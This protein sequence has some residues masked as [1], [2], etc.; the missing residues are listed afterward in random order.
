MDKSEETRIVGFERG[1]IYAKKPDTLPRRYLYKVKSASRDGLISRWMEPVSA[2]AN[3]HHEEEEEQ[4][5]EYDVGDLVNYFMFGDGRGM[6]LGK[7][8]KDI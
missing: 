1:E 2:Y 5:Y 3:E 6:I 7:I 8:R 4:K